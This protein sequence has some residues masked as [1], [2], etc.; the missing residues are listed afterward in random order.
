M[1]A[2]RYYTPA[3]KWQ[4]ALP[5]GNGKTAVMI[6]G[7]KKCERLCFN[8]AQL[9][10]GYPSVHDNP[11]SGQKLD[12]VRKSVFE[13]RY[14]E[15]DSKARAYLCGDYTQAYMPLATADMRFSGAKGGKYSRGLDLKTAVAKVVCGDMYRE[16]FVSHPDDVAVYR[17]E[18][19]DK[20]SLT[21]KLSSQIKKT[22]IRSGTDVLSLCG[23]AP[24]YAAPNYLWLK[25]FPIRYNEGKGMAFAISVRADSDGKVTV[26]KG[27]LRVKDATYVTLYFT[28]D[29]GFRR[30]DTMPYTD[31]V[32][33]TERCE[34]KLNREFSYEQV[35]KDH[36]DDYSALY[37]RHEFTLCEGTGEPDVLL[38]EAKKGNVTPGLIDL[39]YNYGK[40]MT[41]AGSRD[42]QP[43]NLQGQWNNSVRPPWSCNLT[44]N[45][46]FQMN[47]WHAGAV[48]LQE[49]IKP[50]YDCI[51]EIAAR[52]ETT[53][54]INY[55]AD[56]FACNHNV[57][58]WRN[59]S[60]V[61]GDPC[62]MY[63]PLCGVWL[64]NEM[65]ARKKEGG[66]TDKD[67]QDVT[68]AAA[69]FCLDY[70]VEKDGYLV[71]CPSASPEAVFASGASRCA[72][73]Y[74]SAFEMAIIRRCF[75]DCL[76][77]DI[78]AK[79]RSR[80]EEA[81]KKLIPYHSTGD[82][83][84][85]W[86]GDLTITEKGHRHFSPL[87]GIYPARQIGYYGERELNDLAF[88]LFA[89]RMDNSGSSIGWS[90]AW[91]ICLAG[92]FH[93]SKYAEKAVKSM[94]ARSVMRNLFDFHPPAYF[95]IDGNFGFV[96]GINE[97]M[98]YEE[99]SVIEFM[100]AYIKALSSGRIRGHRIC[101]VTLDFDWNDGK[102]TYISA[103]SP[104]KVLAGS[105]AD[106][107]ELHNVEI[108]KE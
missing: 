96:A 42:C 81:Q 66:C 67:A 90:A 85:E 58:I 40:Y 93:S 70:L 60:P 53:A 91:A 16:A 106:G 83:L 87:Y 61:Q 86:N 108:V 84:A 23:N 69:R 100:P 6:Y 76:T 59:T 28:T 27:K 39:M 64:A 19:K 35:R 45:I 37:S 78:D 22:E 14:A 107:A 44:T 18:C 41:I 49:C 82:M 1:D 12:E 94:L 34:N 30:Y 43:L 101:G 31:R 88:R 10:S 73:G 62:Y 103:S 3:G 57:D 50:F 9:W 54:R 29:T 80:I 92:R 11:V 65:F 52:G 24:D 20:F 15:A 7:G 21:L 99:N 97:L 5:L 48:N 26:A 32:K 2:L 79:L 77:C 95:Q 51:K 89:Q 68:V 13:G 36:I 71:T 98:I 56:G 63:A 46:N 47:Y 75:A 104:V 8:D 55:N 74:A 105:I 72:L 17:A 102:V 25:P 38:A 4:E 33:I